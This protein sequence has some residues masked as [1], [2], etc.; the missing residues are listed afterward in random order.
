MK[1]R[2]SAIGKI[3][4]DAKGFGITPKQTETL[5]ELEAKDKRTE[6]QEATLQ[7][8]IAKRDAPEK[9]S[10]GA[11]TYIKSLVNHEVF[12]YRTIINTPQMQ[13][14]TDVEDE[15]IELF[16]EVFSSAFSK[17]EVYLE[18]DFIK[19]ECDL[20]GDDIVIDIKSSWSLDTFPAMP[21]QGID[22]TYEWQLRGYMMLYDVNYATLAYC[23][24][25]T[26]SAL[27]KPWD[28]EYIHRVEHIEPRLRVSILE[29]ER[30]KELENKIIKKVEACRVFYNEYKKQLLSKN[31]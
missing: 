15:S 24:V 26:P 23:M 9:L 14:G 29:F 31:D 1:I 5:K 13:K 21:D 16:N 25:N 10:Q 11:E 2:C 6:K 8:L 7:E 17:N 18:N 4:S 20:L 30:D 3:M 19:G 27:L 12:Q 22:S 28:S